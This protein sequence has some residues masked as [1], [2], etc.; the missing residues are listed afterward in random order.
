VEPKVLRAEDVS[1]TPVQKVLE[2]LS[3]MKKK[4]EEAGHRKSS[5]EID[6][7]NHRTSTFCAN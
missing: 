6:G 1:A 7:E 3:S 5:P 2:L 4:G